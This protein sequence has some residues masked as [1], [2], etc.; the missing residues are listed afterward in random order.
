MQ[1]VSSGCC[2][3]DLCV[4]GDFGCGGLEGVLTNLLRWVW[5]INLFIWFICSGRYAA[6]SCSQ[7][8]EL[9][10]YRRKIGCL[11]NLWNINCGWWFRMRC[12]A[13]SGHTHLIQSTAPEFITH[14]FTQ[15]V[16]KESYHFLMGGNSTLLSDVLPTH[17]TVSLD[18][19]ITFY[20]IL[21]WTIHTVFVKRFATSTSHYRCYLNK[22]SLLRFEKQLDN[23]T[24]TI[25]Q[26]VANQRYQLDNNTLIR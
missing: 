14:S 3:F 22:R 12:M 23:N 8:R 11:K 10:V 18:L 5:L 9:V 26:Q 17:L 1:A 25:R 4:C 2:L 15:F 13:L 24:P 6:Y 19:F 7:I 21:R 16:K 20:Q